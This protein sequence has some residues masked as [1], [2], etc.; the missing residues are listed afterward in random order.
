MTLKAKTSD[1]ER[2]IKMRVILKWCLLLVTVVLIQDFASFAQADEVASVASRLGLTHE[3]KGQPLVHPGVH[4]I[5]TEPLLNRAILVLDHLD[6]K[7]EG[8]IE[9]RNGYLLIEFSTSDHSHTSLAA[10]GISREEWLAY[11]G[12]EV[13]RRRNRSV[14]ERI[15]NSVIPSASAKECSNSSFSFGSFSPIKSFFGSGYWSTV[16]SCASGVLQGVWSATGGLLKSVGQGLWTLLT[17][18]GKFWDDAVSQ[19]KQMKDFIVNIDSK[20]GQ[21][22]SSI[23]EMPNE[24]RA[25]LLCSFIGSIGTDIIIAALTAGAT[26]GKVMLSLAQYAKR[27]L[28]VEKLLSHLSKLK[29]IGK[30]PKSFYQKLARGKIP[31]T[32]L[33]AIETLSKHGFHGK[34]ME[35]VQ[36]VL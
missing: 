13:G 31:D 17:D 11:A 26:S 22:V 5:Y 30:L 32:D 21:I 25:E 12:N 18:P 23:K 20:I 4:R 36:C 10:V 15:F 2:E 27:L 33:N 16:Y 34:S 7:V 9:E 6:G 28:K 29:T 3:I 1:P 14:P 35:V 8:R 24:V 19:F